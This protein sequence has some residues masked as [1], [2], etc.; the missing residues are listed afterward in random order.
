[1]ASWILF[2]CLT[3][4][5]SRARKE[6]KVT[7]ETKGFQEVQAILVLLPTRSQSPMDL[8]GPKRVGSFL[9]RA[10]R[11]TRATQVILELLVLLAL[12]AFLEPKAILA[13]V[14]LLELLVLLVTTVRRLIRSL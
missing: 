4:R 3:Q 5:A 12:L 11:E 9:S 13:I 8:S 7:G 14:A 2:L 6:T 10:L 1:M